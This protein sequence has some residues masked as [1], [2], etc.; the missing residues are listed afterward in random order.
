MYLLTNL[1]NSLEN[2]LSK[3]GMSES[4]IIRLSNLEN[5]DF[6]AIWPLEGREWLQN[7]ATRCG[8]TFHTRQDPSWKLDFGTIFERCPDSDI[9]LSNPTFV[10][11]LGQSV[12]AK[13]SIWTVARC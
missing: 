2:S 13:V 6:C 5:F 9:F 8:I 10:S 3:N 12:S 4:I 1:I 7:D 11:D